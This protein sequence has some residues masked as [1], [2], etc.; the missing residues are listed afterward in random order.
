MLLLFSVFIWTIKPAHA[1]ELDEATWNDE[2]K[3]SGS[4]DIMVLPLA[5]AA[6]AHGIRVLCN[7]WNG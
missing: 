7:W 3:H 1:L 2:A 5:L 4:V 6:K